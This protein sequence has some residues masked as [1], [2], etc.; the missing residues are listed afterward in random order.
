MAATDFV[1]ESQID[2]LTTTIATAVKANETAA[3]TNASDLNDHETAA[4]GAHAASAISF[5]DPGD[6]YTATTVEAAL[7]EVKVIADAAA[8]GG[9]SINDAGTNS[10]QA[11]SSQKIS[12]EIT[13]AVSALIDGAPGALDTLNELAAAIND[14][15]TFTTTVT[16]ALG[17]RVRV[18]AAQGFTSPQQLQGRQNIGV[19]TS[20]QDFASDFTTAIA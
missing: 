9:V 3:A 8:G 2:S 13:A 17:L 11:W 20:T 16:T 15:A 7:A 1:T 10:T 12:D 4:T 5:S 14:D 19:I 6:D 18:D